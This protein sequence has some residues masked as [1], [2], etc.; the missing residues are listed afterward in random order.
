MTEHP[1]KILMDNDPGLI[2]LDR[3][4]SAYEFSD[5]VLPRKVK[6]LMA[7]AIDASLGAVGGVHALAKEALDAGATR[8]EILETARVV[9]FVAGHGRLHVIAQGLKE[10]L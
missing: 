10:V 4:A 3:A 1:L 8:D 7:L 5:G 6:L 9:H 2:D